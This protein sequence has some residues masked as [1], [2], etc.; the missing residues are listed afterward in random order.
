MKT[1][2]QKLT[3]DSIQELFRLILSSYSSAEIQSTPT[4][5][6]TRSVS[7][8][9]SLFI[10]ISKCC[11][12][13]IRYN[14]QELVLI[15]IFHLA[16]GGSTSSVL[17]KLEKICKKHKKKNAETSSF[18]ASNSKFLRTI[19]N[20]GS[21][22]TSEEK[23]L[24]KPQ[25]MGFCSDLLNDSE[26][27]GSDENNLMQIWISLSALV[28][29]YAIKSNNEDINE[30]DAA[31]S[32]AI[33]QLNAEYLSSA[34]NKLRSKYSFASVVV[35]ITAYLRFICDDDADTE[36]RINFKFCCCDLIFNRFLIPLVPVFYLFC[37]HRY[38]HRM[39]KLKNKQI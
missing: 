2:I 15:L 1:C 3:L 26:H 37:L 33:T 38:T 28:K 11:S 25:L 7:G 16:F 17:E 13:S 20:M 29:L 19:L 10:Y 35:L 4:Q 32:K 9:I 36:V 23:A 21:N 27:M 22:F 31:I 24:A 34:D 30:M 8:A 12:E 14:V 5:D 39:S 6:A 18:V